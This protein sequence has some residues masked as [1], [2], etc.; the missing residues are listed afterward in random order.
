MLTK[1]DLRVGYHHI[2]MREEDVHKTTFRTYLRH[3]EYM[4]MPFRLCNV[5]SI[6]QVLMNSIFQSYLRR[7]I[8]IFFDDI[9]VYSKSLEEHAK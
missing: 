2:R 3:Y 1:L 6:F 5:P 8:L 7:F 4:V 9:L